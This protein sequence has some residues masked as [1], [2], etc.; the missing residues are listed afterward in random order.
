MIGVAWDIGTAISG[1][2]TLP[3]SSD[4]IHV[5][6]TSI[7]DY[8]SHSA[9]IPARYYNLG[10]VGQYAGDYRDPGT[11]LLYANQQV[12]GSL[13]GADGWYWVL[14]ANVLGTIYRGVGMTDELTV[15]CRVTSSATQTLTNTTQVPLLFDSDV[16]DPFNMHDTVTNTSRITVPIAGVYIIGASVAFATSS[17]GLREVELRVNGSYSIA[18]QR[19]AAA[20]NPERTGITLSAGVHLNA[21]DYVE[22]RCRQDSG[23]PLGTYAETD[24]TPDLW[25]VRV[26]Q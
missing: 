12:S 14:P 10:Q 3:G 15:A 6:L 9:A 5:A 4:L 20:A 7:P 17:T 18:K 16:L 1:E 11:R 19:I 21:G 24:W 25:V 22:C 13:P 2:G 23:G 8:Y 26:G